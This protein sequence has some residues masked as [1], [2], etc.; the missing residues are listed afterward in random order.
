MTSLA[1]CV[2]CICVA[3]AVFA[4]ACGSDDVRPNRAV[5][6]ATDAADPVSRTSSAAA[7][8]SGDATRRS[9]GV[10]GVSATLP[11]GG[12]SEG[13]VPLKP[14]SN[15]APIKVGILYTVND[16]AESA[17]IDNGDTIA[18]SE[19]VRAF[20]KSYNASGGIGGRRID[21]VYR[22]LNSSSND[23]EG[24]MQAA[25]AAFTED[26]HVEV[27]LNGVGYY[28]DTLMT[29]LAKASVPVVSGDW[30]APDRQDAKRFPLMVTPVTLVGEDRMSAVVKHLKASG[31]LR[32]SSRIG[33]VVEDCPIDQRVYSNGLKPAVAAA[34]LKITWTFEVSCFQSIQDYAQQTSQMSSAVLQ[35]R[36]RGVDRVMFVS[37]GAEAN[38][39]FAFSTV[40]ESQGW[41][42]SYALSSVAAPV[43][44]ALNMAE[45]QLRNVRGVG[46]LPLV[47]S[48]DPKQTSPTPTG[49]KCLERMKREGITPSSNTDHVFIYGTCDVFSL[50][51]SILRASGGDARA[52]AVL[53]ALK[54]IG[55]RYVAAM[56]IGGKVSMSGGRMRAFVGRLFGW[57]GSRSRF[58]YASGTFAL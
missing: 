34:G 16:A 35:F 25:C 24:G 26:N 32:P 46:W 19:V 7:P 17:G 36:Q 5:A 4:F 12:I 41:H 18:P 29:C 39:V 42:P 49:A 23:Y 43:A 9:P 50:Y 15:R 10:A 47:D 11:P 38:L 28:S 13:T 55:A 51:D 53:G 31:Y 3:F 20:V 22:N 45:G 48:H 56:T 6:S 30:V 37:Q 14:G 8:A 52:N 33:V 57:V 2:R 54:S 27:V 21:P 58:E 1:R 44:L 40:A